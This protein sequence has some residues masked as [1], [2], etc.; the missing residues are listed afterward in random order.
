M[1]A[2]APYE[3]HAIAIATSIVAVVVAVAINFEGMKRLGELYTRHRK[4]SGGPVARHHML[5]M[6]FGLL[7][8]HALA[9]L[10]FGVGYWALLRVPEAGSI[11]GAH[12][13][14]VFDAFYLSAM[15]YST[16]GFGDLTPK[17]PIRWLAGAEALVGLMMI[18]WSASFAFLEMSRHWRDDL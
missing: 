14:S 7:V 5:W 13:A 8:L 10:V 4:R 17:G 9:M 15:T 11:D 1:L 3:V 18:A 6:V 2:G 12:R 16:V